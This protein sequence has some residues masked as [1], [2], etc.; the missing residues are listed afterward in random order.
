M[1]GAPLG[2]P[3]MSGA[4]ETDGPAAADAAM[5][6]M[7]GGAAAA[8]K[9][10]SA[11]VV[12]IVPVY[13]HS[14]L[15]C[16]ALDS[17]LAQPDAPRILGVIVNDGCKFPETHWTCLDYATAHPDRLVYLQ[18]S[19]QGLSAARNTGIE[20]A[21]QNVDGLEAVY[22]LD[23]DNI[24]VEGGIAEAWATMRESGAD[25]VYPPYNATGVYHVQDQIAPFTASQLMRLNYMDAGSLLHRRMLDAG[26]RFDASMRKGYEDWEF[27][28]LATSKGFKGEYGRDLGL[29]YR[30]RPESMLSDSDMLRTEIVAG[31]RSKHQAF[32]HPARQAEVA[33]LERDRYAIMLPNEDTAWMTSFVGDVPRVSSKSELERGLWQAIV[34]GSDHAA[35]IFYIWTDAATW[36][37]L[38][39]LKVLAWLLVDAERSL[40]DRPIYAA[41]LEA[42]AREGEVRIAV[43]VAGA[44]RRASVVVMRSDQVQAVVK[45]D[46]ILWLEEA[47]TARAAPD[48]VMVRT[49]HV[50]KSE[51]LRT[52]YA[53]LAILADLERIQKSAFRGAMH[54]KWQWKNTVEFSNRHAIFED[55]YERAAPLPWRP[56]G[57]NIVF[58]LPIAE[59]GGADRVTYNVAHALKQSGWTPHLL[60]TDAPK[61]RLPS[62]FADTFATI[63][64][65]DSREAIDW[66]GRG[67]YYGTGLS[68]WGRGGGWIS[69]WELVWFSKA[70]VNNHSVVT[71]TIIGRLKKIGV[72]SFAYQHLLEV[73]KFGHVGGHPV[74]GL[75]YESGYAGLLGCSKAICDWLVAEGAPREKVLEI[76]NGPGFL[77]DKARARSIA[78]AR[79]SRSGE[80]L[81][82]LYLGRLDRQKGLGPLINL[83]AKST[84]AGLPIEWRIVG[85]AMVEE[86]MPMPAEFKRAIEPPVFDADDVLAVLGWA[87]VIVLM[88]DYEGLPLVLV[89]A[90]LCGV[91]PVS[92]NVGAIGELV[93]DGVDG[94]LVDPE[95]REREALTRLELLCAD[96][97][98]L[99]SM[100]G[101]AHE[102]GAARNNWISAVE[103]LVGMIDAAAAVR[104]KAV[105][106]EA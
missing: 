106:A 92:T 68:S 34:R 7:A 20:W 103:P 30:K 38:K 37:L 85:E 45:D 104:A 31:M 96:R 26:L 60:V 78:E 18:Q 46:D 87:D 94:F 48:H 61:F 12:V 17:V 88:S 73:D 81:R 54:A 65:L 79:A 15:M 76:R 55:P 40:R 58:A 102:T 27:W 51:R 77:V 82:V 28:L 25:W 98:R 80:K 49:I 4:G 24:L 93:R 33:A 70:L 23:A 16:D 74:L 9:P 95:R 21:L 56:S 35:P 83:H 32:Y 101:R 53:G 29:L 41:C 42:D 71:N 43:A 59:F 36:D 1:G 64:F 5:A 2:E 90:M 52:S 72:M 6:T 69:L 62:D 13:G 22:L 67:F 75:A 99:Q 84:K 86:R 91:V 10:Y 66:S 8:A 11:E 63:S 100:A 57:K 3:E 89:E 105:A 19:N 97:A 39:R 44:L 50:P 47:L 14:I